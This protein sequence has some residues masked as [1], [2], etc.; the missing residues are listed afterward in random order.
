MIKHKLEGKLDQ[1]AF[2]SILLDI[3]NGIDIV[4]ECG[5]NI[6]PD[7]ANKIAGLG[8]TVFVTATDDPGIKETIEN[9]MLYPLQDVIVEVP[10]SAKG[11]K[12]GKVYEFISD[13][14]SD[15]RFDGTRLSLVDVQNAKHLV[16]DDQWNCLIVHC[17]DHGINL[18][19]EQNAAVKRYSKYL[20]SIS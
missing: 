18:Y 16:K 14:I 7:D 3:D 17:Y 9:L 10:V 6:D 13:Y 19:W 8:R 20:W 4:I 12:T 15:R 1:K 2:D 11:I 5:P